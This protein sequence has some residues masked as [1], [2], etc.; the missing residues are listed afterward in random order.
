MPR[1][2]VAW[3]RG[4]LTFDSGAAE[5]LT[6]AR[7]IVDERPMPA[8]LTLALVGCGAISQLHLP[9]VRSGA[10]RTAI[11]AVVD[12]E[13]S[14]ARAMAER[15]GARPF[16]SLDA[17]LEAGGFDAVDLMLP[18][19]VHESAAVRC[20]AAGKHV[21]LEKPMAN[22]VASCERIL[23]AARRAGTVF[24]IAENTQ[25]W[26][27]VLAAKRMIADGVLGEVI[28]AHASFALPP[29]KEFYGD[30]AWRLD[31]AS[32]GGGIALDAGSHWIRPLRLWLGEVDEVVGA[33]GHPWRAMQGE[34]LV[35]ALLRFRS[36]VV[37]SLDGLMKDAPFADAP[38]FRVSGQR[39]DLTIDR[40]AR[41]VLWDTA[42]PDGTRLEVEGGGY[43]ESFYAQL[44]DFEAA[45]L[46]GRPLA[47]PAEL[48]LG[49]LRTALALYR[50]AKSGRWEKVWE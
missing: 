3:W 17:A 36:G 10:V 5:R 40:T 49:E 2:V 16:T 35:R 9:A 45:I 32:A 6:A 37:A 46:D 20:F 11:T 28:T 7:W 18:H 50:S 30:G 29:M 25:Y 44:A 34:S 14:R 27:E 24:Q 4:A 21:L 33:L 13:E 15:T 19:H 41:L 8:Q 31:D 26:G 42:H 47:A 39:A 22:D 38:M 12:T 43:L 48:A 23:A 1:V